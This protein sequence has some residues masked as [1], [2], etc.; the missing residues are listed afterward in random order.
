METVQRSSVRPA[1]I[2]EL[3]IVAGHLAL[4][5]AN[6]VDDPLGPE[7]FDHVIDY[8]GLLGWASRIGV[9]PDVTALRQAAAEQPRRAAAAVRRGAEL[10]D[11]L[12]EV[13]GALVDRTSPEDGWARLRPFVSTAIQ[14][15]TLSPGSQPAP[16]WEFTDLESPLWPVA[17]S[18][19]SLLNSPLTSKL[20]RCAGCPWLFLDQSRN[21]SRRWCSME[22]CGTAQKIDRYVAKRAARPKR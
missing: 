4:D 14:Q 13:F 9:V 3:P 11:A 2:R 10:R 20:K 17:E 7:R 8:A 21:G 22:L 18:A 16:A 12:N 19:Y 15:A 5:F 1:E 6:T